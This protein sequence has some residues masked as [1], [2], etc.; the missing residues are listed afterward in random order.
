MSPHRTKGGSRVVA[1]PSSGSGTRLRPLAEPR[2]VAVKTDE[3]GDP[4]AVREGRR[5]RRVEARGE[6]WRIDDEWWRRPVSRLYH[7]I[8]LEDGGLRTLYHDLE[9]R[10]WFLHP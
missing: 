9:N 10:R 6:S 5:W 1:A 3:R 7:R 2:P 8:V 4:V